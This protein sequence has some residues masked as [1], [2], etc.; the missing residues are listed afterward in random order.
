MNGSGPVHKSLQE[1]LKALPS[2]TDRYTIDFDYYGMTLEQ[3]QSYSLY[4]QTILIVFVSINSICIG[5]LIITGI[6]RRKKL[7]QH[8]SDLKPNRFESVRDSFR[9]LRSRGK[10]SFRESKNRRVDNL[11]KRG[12]NL[13]DSLRSR[14]SE[15]GSSFK[16]K[17]TTLSTGTERSDAG[18]N[19]DNEPSVKV[20]TPPPYEQYDEKI[21]PVLPRYI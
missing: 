2:K 7:S 5:I 20:Q 1:L 18:T 15:I 12:S 3:V 9:R 19:T 8:I 13:R 11:R 17:L 4:S 6:W 21:Y 14:G 16:R 10:N